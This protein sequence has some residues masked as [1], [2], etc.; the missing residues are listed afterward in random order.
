LRLDKQGRER[1]GRGKGNSA[2]KAGQLNLRGHGMKRHGE[3]GESRRKRV[4]REREGG[5]NQT[6]DPLRA[7]LTTKRIRKKK[8][9]ALC[10]QLKNAKL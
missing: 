5:E 10:R 3:R 6:V 7:K 2:R 9:G 8:K 1:K 4:A